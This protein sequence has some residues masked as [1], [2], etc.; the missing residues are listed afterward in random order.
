MTRVSLVVDIQAGTAVEVPM[1]PEEEATFV[2]SL[3]PDPNDYPLSM[4]N[5]RLGILAAGYSVEDIETEF[6]SIPDRL[7]RETV[8][9]WWSTAQNIA[10]NHE[11]TQQLLVIAGFTQEQARVMWVNRVKAILAGA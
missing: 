7:I 2:A 5:L 10:W 8:W 4:T 9:T 6:L 1:T 11:Y 3:E